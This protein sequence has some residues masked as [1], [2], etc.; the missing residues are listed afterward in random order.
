M[1]DAK[2]LE[3]IPIARAGDAV[4][5]LDTDVGDVERARAPGSIVVGEVD[6]P[7]ESV[8]IGQV[9]NEIAKLGEL[10]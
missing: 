6:V 3:G 4:E 10:S 1:G 8:I 5:K 2:R 7:P 9:G